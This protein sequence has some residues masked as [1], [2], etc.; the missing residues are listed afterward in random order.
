[1]VSAPEKL[2]DEVIRPV[3]I[4]LGVLLMKTL[5]ICLE[6]AAMGAGYVLLYPILLNKN[7]SLKLNGS[8]MCSA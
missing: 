5:T 6:V 1:M 8:H 7:S 4:F 2:S 3:Q